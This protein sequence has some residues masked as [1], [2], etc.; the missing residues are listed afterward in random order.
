MFLLLSSAASPRYKQ[1]ILRCLAAPM[2][3]RIQFRYAREL[4][5]PAVLDQISRHANQ[6][7][8]LGDGLVCF[9]NTQPD[10][11]LPLYPV[12]KVRI[13]TVTVHGSTLSL[14]LRMQDFAHHQNPADFT[15]HVSSATSGLS[16]HKD[17][18]GVV[19]GPYFFS[20]P[21]NAQQPPLGGLSLGHSIALWET[22]ARQL[23]GTDTF[24]GEAFFWTVLG[25]SDPVH[26]VTGEEGFH[27]W[28]D[29]LQPSVSRAL[30]I[31][32]YRPQGEDM[33]GAE[34]LVQVG[35]P[36][37]GRSPEKIEIDSSYDL[38]RW[39]F[40]TDAKDWR[41]HYG[42]IRIRSNDQ[43][44]L[45]LPANLPGSWFSLAGKAILAGTFIA[46][47]SIASTVL[48]HS[49]EITFRLGGEPHWGLITTVVLSLVLGWSAAFLF[50][51]NLPRVRA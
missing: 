38:K 17:N 45:D 27:A 19:Q 28:D 35:G 14:A 41:T 43:W 30:L 37:E 50:L 11:L 31:Y 33:P 1:D 22:V 3:A 15:E 47:P 46:G 7:G 10:G 9:L 6:P 51:L 21:D 34:L 20:V 29:D 5:A 36:L 48:Q 24:Q 23:Q 40:R 2:N 49:G 42:W 39:L 26:A 16:P 18:Q 32:H 4:V 44:N 8:P 12:R 25:V 13:E